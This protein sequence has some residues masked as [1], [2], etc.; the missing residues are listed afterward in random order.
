MGKIKEKFLSNRIPYDEIDPEM[1]D[2]LNVLNFHLGLKTKY[3]C[4][5]HDPFEQISLVFDEEVTDEQ[6]YKLA[7]HTWPHI[8]YNKWVRYSPI[9]INWTCIIGARYKDP[10]SELKLSQ[11]E[12]IVKH[13]KTLSIL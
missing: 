3:C 9:K 8:N 12:L 6:I 5:G 4:Y 10:N 2:I 1:I 11:L 7:E 13:L